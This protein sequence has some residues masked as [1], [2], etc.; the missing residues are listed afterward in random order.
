MSSRIAWLLLEL[1][2]SS[3]RYKPAR[4]KLEE[5]AM[6]CQ[7]MPRSVSGMPARTYFFSCRRWLLLNIDQL[8]VA[9]VF[10]TSALAVV[11]V[12]DAALIVDTTIQT[13]K[14][15]EQFEVEQLQ[16]TP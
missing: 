11:P 8:V 13:E 7:T 3:C 15:V 4:R 5:L 2:L 1:Q 10:Q 12:G 6:R 9:R 14:M 16:N